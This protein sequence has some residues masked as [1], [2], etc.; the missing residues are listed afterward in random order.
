M[1]RMT[2]KVDMC[3]GDV[4]GFCTV[5]KG[6]VY[7]VTSRRASSKTSRKVYSILA[8]G[9]FLGEVSHVQLA[10]LFDEKEIFEEKLKG[11]L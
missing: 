4:N 10:M 2:A 6:Y 8:S 9:K 7:K 11:N 1:I 5:S 3:K